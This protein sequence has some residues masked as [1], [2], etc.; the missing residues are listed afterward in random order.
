MTLQAEGIR[1]V[2]SGSSDG[3]GKLR[4]AAQILMGLP[5]KA[6]PLIH[7]PEDL[8]DVDFIEFLAESGKKALALGT[9]FPLLVL[10]T[11]PC[12]NEG[13]PNFLEEYLSQYA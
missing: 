13:D 6:K 2:D 8:K 11:G 7:G 4:E 3:I 1:L 9:V 5:A 12:S 10:L